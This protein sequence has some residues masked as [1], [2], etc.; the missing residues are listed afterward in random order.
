MKGVQLRP[1]ATDVRV[2]RYSPG[3]QPFRGHTVTKAGNVAIFVKHLIFMD[4]QSSEIDT[5]IL[6]LAL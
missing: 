4:A 3:E 2:P 1:A 5:G 6:H